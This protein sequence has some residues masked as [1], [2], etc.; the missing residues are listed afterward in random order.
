MPN[1]KFQ[2]SRSTAVMNK[3]RA[4]K[5]NVN[6]E[7][8]YEICRA[9]VQKSANKNIIAEQ[10]TLKPSPSLPAGAVVVS[11]AAA[12][13][14]HIGFSQGRVGSKVE[15]LAPTT[16]MTTVPTLT[17]AAPTVILAPVNPVPSTSA[18]A[19]G[20][21]VAAP[22]AVAVRPPP[23][24][25]VVVTASSLTKVCYCVKVEMIHL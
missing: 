20:T 6:V 22:F 16:V 21:T 5:G 10:V 9:V 25:S 17:G 2:Q 7:R 3:F 24:V 14:G 1:F 11:A 19:A 23:P 12:S 4:P 13:Q 18:A 8:S 15:F